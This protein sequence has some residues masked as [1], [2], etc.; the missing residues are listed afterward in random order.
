MCVLVHT[1][2]IIISFCSIL[3][4]KELSL[5][6]RRYRFE[7][8]A[9][10]KKLR[11]KEAKVNL[12]K[13]NGRLLGEEVFLELEHFNVK[14]PK[15]KTYN[16][17]IVNRWHLYLRLLMNKELVVYRKK[18]LENKKNKNSNNDLPHESLLFKIK[19]CFQKTKCY[20]NNKTTSCQM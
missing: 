8:F 11:N 2:P 19:N 10:L 5:H 20:K 7:K 16:K 6:I 14:P 18:Y 15:I 9:L 13:F 1:N 17:T 4:Y 12:K 3:Y